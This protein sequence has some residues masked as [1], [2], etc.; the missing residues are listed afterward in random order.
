MKGL[1]GPGQSWLHS[2][3]LSENTKQNKIKSYLLTVFLVLE[4]CDTCT[5]EAGA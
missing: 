1:Q 5:W 4:A 2:E 3:I